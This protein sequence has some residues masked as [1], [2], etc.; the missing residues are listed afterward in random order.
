MVDY[1]LWEVIE[2]GNSPLITQ[3]FKGVETT[4]SP[5]TAEEKAQRRWSVTTATK[6]DTL[7]GSAELQEVKIPSIRK[8]QEG[9]CLWNHLLQVS[10]DGL[11]GYDWSDQAEE[12]E[13]VNEPIVTEPI[14]K[15]PAVETSEAKASADKPKVVK[16][17]FGPPLIKDWIPDS[18]DD[19]E[20]KSKNEK[21]TVKPSFT[22]IKFVKSKEQVKSHRKTIVK[23][24]SPTAKRNMAP[25]SVLLKSGTVNAAR[26]K[27]SKIIVLVNTARQVSTAH[28]KST[29]NVARPKS[30]LSNTSHSIVKRPIHKKTTFTN[31][32]VPQKVNNVRSKT[33]NTGKPKAVVNDVQ[34][35]GNP[36]MDLQ[37]KR[38][39]NS[40][41]SRHMT[42][43]MSYLT[44]YE[45]ID[46]GYVAFGGNPKEGKITGKG[47]FDG[48][49]D[50][51]FFVGYSLNSKAFR[52]FNNRTRIVE[53]NLHIKFSENTLN[54]A[55]SEPNW[56]FN[57]DALTK[58]MN[59]KPV[60]TG[61]QSNANAGIKACDDAGKARI[62]TVHGKDY[63][64]L[65]L[66]TADPLIYQ[67][68]KSSQDDGFQPSSN[69][70]N[71]VN[72]HPRKESEC[73]DQEK[74]DNVNNTNNFNVVG[75]NGVNVVGANTNN[76]LPFDLEMFA[77]ED[78]STFNFLSDHEDDDK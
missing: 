63:I 52:V 8:A 66:W 35:N 36:Q 73:K 51:G 38:V 13:F 6:E 1:S 67:E 48:K 78:I 46:E 22:K 2:N 45:E 7:L 33:V 10:C 25:R 3:V 31:S 18:E 24:D 40:G 5:T 60:V 71:K 56:L 68:S 29:V 23:Q 11:G 61:N 20:S 9:L 32:N 76:E 16:K 57:I 42:R 44:V 70:G 19:A 26:Q 27:L 43:K 4:I 74:E 28:P 77:L 21:K 15:K 47:K 55:E 75:S 49:A 37:D 59:Y 62:K 17:N 53:E 58:S 34:G 39:I 12:E 72:E 30:H 64:L 54:I 65:P 41:Y 69:D 14:V 50:E